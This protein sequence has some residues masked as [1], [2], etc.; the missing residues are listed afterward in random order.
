M[1]IDDLHGTIKELQEKGVALIGA[2]QPVNG[3]VFIHPR[4]TH[5]VLVQLKERE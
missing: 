1:A 2:E 5:G 4:A 3:L